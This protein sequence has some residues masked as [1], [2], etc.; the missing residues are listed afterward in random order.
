MALYL[1]R[2]ELQQLVTQVDSHGK[3]AQELSV[4]RTAWSLQSSSRRD[5]LRVT[6]EGDE[7]LPETD[8]VLGHCTSSML[9]AELQWGLSRIGLAGALN[10]GIHAPALDHVFRWL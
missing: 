2:Q 4:Q 3:A 5:L 9:R 8:H 7:E 1:P 10:D 6:P